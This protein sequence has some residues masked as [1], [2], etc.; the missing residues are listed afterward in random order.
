M[1]LSKRGEIYWIRFSHKG[2]RI[3]KSTGTSNKVAAQEMDDRLKAQLWRIDKL[4]EQ[5]AYTWQDAVMR[6]LKE[7]THKRSLACDKMHLRWLS[8]YLD[9]R[10]LHEISSEL[11]ESI[12][13]AKEDE[14]VSPATIN[15]MLEVL[16]ALLRK[17]ETQWHWLESAPNIRL[18]REKK[19]RIRWLTMAEADRLIKELP[20]HLASMATF[21][22]A[23]G[24]RMSNVTGLKWRDINLKNHHA[25]IHPDKAKANKAISVPLNE[26]AM[27]IL[28]EQMGVH[29]E[30][31]FTYK[32]ERIKQ[33]N[34]RAWRLALKK[35]QIENFRW[36]DLRHMW[37]FWHI[38]NGITLQKLQLLGR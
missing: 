12:I 30:Y 38:Q 24:L 33:Y 26:M 28:E 32:G 37:A 8:P 13:A 27:K 16:R 19:R 22:L 7:S 34:T 10:F 2:K 6:W 9:D 4:G 36:H 18:R 29:R 35:A 14:N 15:R 1:A 20:P 25:W 5:S 3:Q 31:V 17:A 23:T 11:L 21:T